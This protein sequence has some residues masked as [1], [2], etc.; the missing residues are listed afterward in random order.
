MSFYLR[1]EWIDQEDG[2]QDVS[3]CYAISPVS[4]EPDWEHD[5]QERLLRPECGERRKR[6]SKVIKLPRSFEDQENYLL[7]YYFQYLQ[8]GQHCQTPVYIDE[9]NADN[10]ITFIDYWGCYTNICVYWSINGWGA[11]NYSTM[12]MPQIRLDHPLS[13]IHFYGRAY[14]GIYIYQRYEYLR[15]FPLPHIYY[16]RVHGPRGARVEYC[17]HIMRRGSPFGDDF[18]FWDNNDGLNY[19]MEI[20]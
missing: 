13:A 10:T 5:L 8:H 20:K 18:D 11:P 15:T 19:F 2:I 17:Y 9:F 6:R 1:K 7:H 12:F 14:D 4:C 16:G 3:I